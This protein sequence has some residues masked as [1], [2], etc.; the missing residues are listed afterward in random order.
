MSNENYT[1]GKTKCGL[2]LEERLKTNK[3]LY[4]KVANFFQVTTTDFNVLIKGFKCKN[5]AE[6]VRLV[7]LLGR[8]QQLDE[9]AATNCLDTDTVKRLK[10]IIR[11]QTRIY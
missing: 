9:F 5:Q 7:Y 4:R 3:N 10:Y 8:F 11:F 2:I 6:R 1:F